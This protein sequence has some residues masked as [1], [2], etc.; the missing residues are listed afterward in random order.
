MVSN[1]LPPNDR[2]ADEKKT[3][4]TSQLVDASSSAEFYGSW[5]TLLCRDIRKV[6]IGL[7]LLRD[8]DGTYLPAAVWPGPVDDV[9]ALAKAAEQAIAK[10][11]AVVLQ[12]NSQATPDRAEKVGRTQIAQP[13]VIDGEVLG[14]VVLE[15]RD[16]T[17]AEMVSAAHRI[18]WSLGWP[19][20][21]VRRQRSAKQLPGLTR[22][23]VVLSVL[24]AA[25]TH[26]RFEPTA[27]AMANEIA[28]RFGADRV[29]IGMLRRQS[30]R[31]AAMSHS[32]RFDKRSQLVQGLEAAM[33]EAF[34]QHAPVAAPTTQR[35]ARRINV[36]HTTLAER[37]GV[38]AVL[39]VLLSAAGS[40]VGVLTLERP[41]NGTFDDTDL[42]VLQLIANALGP[43]L[44]SRYRQERWFG[45]QSAAIVWKGWAA[46]ADRERPSSRL[47]AVV[48]LAAMVAVAFWPATFRIGAKAVVEGQNL[49]VAPAPFDGFI[50]AATVRAGDTV[51]AGQ[52]I[53]RLDDRDLQLERLKFEMEEQ[54]LVRRQREA[55]AKHERAAIAILAAQIEQA[56]SQLELVNERLRRTRI[57]TP[58]DG[59][60]V[61]GDLSQML[62]APVSQGK[63][64]FEIAP[65]S[66]YRLVVHVD[67]RDIGFVAVGQK[68]LLLLKGVSERELPIEVT[69]ASA[70]AVSDEGH[71]VFKIEA[72]I[73]SSDQELRPGMEGIAKIEV[74]EKSLA[75]IW[76]RPIIERLRLLVWSW[77][78]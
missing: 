71:N 76:L 35:T 54:R 15:L 34:D 47:A 27:I 73:A 19:D 65:M 37:E 48:G 41:P 57:T 12:E 36:A 4:V 20:S 39:S 45:G 43:L 3:D 8:E 33:Q 74:G 67:E 66:A 58:I 32:T 9:S 52:E 16:T 75:A 46:L 72:A 31:V 28:R 53:A 24:A 13:L 49:R 38:G 18:V 68:G 23:Q 11:T 30:L 61:S 42:E 17:P 59:V 77:T 51:R 50:S 29:S 2:L 6:S 1:A 69:R 44:E 60:V 5:L 21:M 70:V 56:R 22:E 78:P 10:A 14:A 7:L 63:V 55:A 25:D 26:D 64:L 40:P 62:G